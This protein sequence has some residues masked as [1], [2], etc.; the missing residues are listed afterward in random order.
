MNIGVFAVDHIRDDGPQSRFAQLFAVDAAAHLTLGFDRIGVADVDDPAILQTKSQPSRLG[1]RRFVT[2]DE[3]GR[4]LVK[5]CYDMALAGA[6]QYPVVC[7][8]PFGSADEAF[9]MHEH[10]GFILGVDANAAGSQMVGSTW[11]GCQGIVGAS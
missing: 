10:H 1:E 9:F 4:D 2:G 3:I 6:Q 11:S 8:E 7:G 5:C